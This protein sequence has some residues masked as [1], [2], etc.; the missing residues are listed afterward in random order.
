MTAI[1]QF[2]GSASDLA[3]AMQQAVHRVD[4]GLALASPATLADQ[5][6]RQ[7]APRRITFLLT[8]AFALTAVVLA[9]LGIFGV[10]SYTVAQRTQEI[11]VRMA[12]GAD[13]GMIL[14]WVMGYGG[15]A[16]GAGLLAGIALTIS[17]GRVLR[18]FVEGIDAL[19]PIVILASTAVLAITG[20]AA[21]LLPALRA[22][23]VSPV[24]AL[25]EG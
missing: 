18:S 11:G 5:I 23:R 6:A 21:C 3:R 13:G 10:M 24:E 17:T 22:T 8:S 15:A 12:L 4:P 16:I 9:A 7:T 25:R 1:V 20:A 2:T 14:R 19:D